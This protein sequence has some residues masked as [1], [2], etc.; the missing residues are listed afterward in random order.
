MLNAKINDTSQKMLLAE[1]FHSCERVRNNMDTRGSTTI[2]LENFY[3]ENTKIMGLF[4]DFGHIGYITKQEKFKKQMTDKQI[5]AI[6]V[7]YDKNHTRDIYK[8]YN[9][10]TKRVIMDRDVNWKD[11]KNT[12]PA[13]T[14]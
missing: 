11:W 14:L 3:G 9:P 5:K 10:E 6:M 13:E 8:L 12:D 7:G 1:A 4:S 2:P